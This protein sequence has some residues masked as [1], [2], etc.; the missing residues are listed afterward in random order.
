MSKFK[1]GDVVKHKA[2]D[3]KMVVVWAPNHDTIRCEYFDVFSQK[4]KQDNF[5]EEVL[6]QWDR[7]DEWKSKN[8]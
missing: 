1:K 7:Q 3:Q 6:E 2:G 5:I 4:F 8:G